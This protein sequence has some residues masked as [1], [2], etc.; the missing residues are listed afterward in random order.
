MNSLRNALFPPDEDKN[1]K[2]QHESLGTVANIS[3]ISPLVSFQPRVHA[4]KAEENRLQAALVVRFRRVDSSSGNKCCLNLLHP[5]LRL[6]VRERVLHSVGD[7]PHAVSL[8]EHFHHPATQSEYEGHSF[9][10]NNIIELLAQLM[11]VVWNFELQVVGLAIFFALILRPVAVEERE[12]VELLLQGKHRRGA[13]SS[14][15]IDHYSPA[16]TRDHAI[17]IKPQA[18]NSFAMQYLLVL[19]S[20]VCI[21]TYKHYSHSMRNLFSV[22]QI[23]RSM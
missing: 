14:T 6:S 2:K 15:T 1:V 7:H 19:D 3:P 22:F 5:A 16:Y 11:E 17:L 21:N 20:Y 13:T 9:I 10:W 12:E 8:P 4:G 18:K 23:N